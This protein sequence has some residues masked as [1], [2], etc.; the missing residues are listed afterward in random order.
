MVVHRS[1]VFSL[2]VAPLLLC[3]VLLVVCRKKRNKLSHLHELHVDMPPGVVAKVIGADYHEHGCM[4]Q[5]KRP[6][7]G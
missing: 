7:C 3:E 2:L 4:Y 1:E 5:G 6:R